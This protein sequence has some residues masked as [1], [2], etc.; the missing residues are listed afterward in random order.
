MASPNTKV[1]SKTLSK[2]DAKKRLAI[3]TRSM[4][5]LPEFINGSHAIRIGL[6][7]GT[8][9]WPIQY[10]ISK[11]GSNKRPSFTSGWTQF[12]ACNGLKP[13]DEISL[14]KVGRSSLYRVE[15]DKAV[16]GSPSNQHRALPSPLLPLNHGVGGTNLRNEPQ[17]LPRAADAATE[18]LY[19]KFPAK[20]MQ[21]KEKSD[22]RLPSGQNF[23]ADQ[24]LRPNPKEITR[25][26]S[27]RVI[28]AEIS[29]PVADK[30]KPSPSGLPAEGVAMAAHGGSGTSQLDAAG[31]ACC[32]VATDHPR[33]GL[34][35][36]PE[37]PGQ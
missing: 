36:V 28:G 4:G 30:G 34:D 11:N 6:N 20:T 17:Q 26:P 21:V 19:S 14:H 25:A 18:T 1:F 8:K 10:T 33:L 5:S 29:D 23:K 16:D 37:N 22:G 7:C 27:P 35:L 13:G 2:T 32:K 12:V 3:P 15:V 24:V 31:E 9:T